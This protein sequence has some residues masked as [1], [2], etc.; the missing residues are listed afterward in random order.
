MTESQPPSRTAEVTF[1]FG[2]DNYLGLCEYLYG[3][4]ASGWWAALADLL[5]GRPGWRCELDSDGLAWCFGPIGTGM[6]IVPAPDTV[7]AFETTT[8]RLFDYQA[9][10]SVRFNSTAELRVWL[11]ANEHRHAEHLR[12]MTWYYSEPG[13]WGL[14]KLYAWPVKVTYDGTFWIGTVPD[15][16]SEVTSAGSLPDLLRRVR[17]LIAHAVGAPVEV[18]ADIS[19]T[20]ALDQPAAAAL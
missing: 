12:S 17:E 9:D 14:L 4:A 18:A 11:E 5:S 6:F 15:I 19:L 20:A 7:E 1:G 8:Y 10:E 3:D 16:P 13:D 2:S